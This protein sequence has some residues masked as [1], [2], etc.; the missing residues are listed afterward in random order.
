MSFIQEKHYEPEHWLFDAI[1][2]MNGA[3]ATGR[4]DFDSAE[5][6]LLDR[7]AAIDS[8]L[9]KI[10]IAFRALHHRLARERLVVL[11]E[12]WQKPDD[13]DR[14]RSQVDDTSKTP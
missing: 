10:P 8:Q 2:S 3:I 7:Y 4:G 1:E 6:T 11:Y 14:W 12:Q 9:D 5:E 13:A